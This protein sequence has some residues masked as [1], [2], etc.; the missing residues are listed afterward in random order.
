MD[1][2]DIISRD[3]ENELSMQMYSD[4]AEEIATCSND[5]LVVAEV[6]TQSCLMID[7]AGDDYREILSSRVRDLKML[8]GSYKTKSRRFESIAK[9]LAGDIEEDVVL[10]VNAPVQEN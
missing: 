7:T 5:L 3:S 6:I 8:A 1:Y 2:K 4:V 10:T 9:R